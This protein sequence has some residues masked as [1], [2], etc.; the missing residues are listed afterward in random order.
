MICSHPMLRSRAQSHDLPLNELPKIP[1]G[2]SERT[3]LDSRIC[4]KQQ[5]F[6]RRVCSQHEHRLLLCQASASAQGGPLQEQRESEDGTGSRNGTEPHDA[7]LAATEA[8]LEIR[9][10]QQSL[11]GTVSDPEKIQRLVETA[12]LAAVGGVLF[13][14]ATVLK[15]QGYS[16]YVQPMPIVIAAMRWGPAAGRKA[17]TATCFLLLVLLGPL[18]CLTFLLNHGLLAASLGAFWSVQAH[19]ALSVPAAAL[20]RVGGQL[21]YIA[22]TSWTLNENLFA[23]LMSNVYSLLD[24]FNAFIGTSGAPP[25]TV[26]VVVIG[27]M[28]TVNAC[29][30]NFLMHVVYAVLLRSMGY[31][32]TSVPKPVERMIFRQQVA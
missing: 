10:Q 15:L 32:V 19:W 25:P 28:L 8:A 29:L 5:T 21:T 11:P 31:T 16:A 27:S 14:L 30:Y 1:T 3:K 7:S 18:Q 23:L 24:Q 20:V 6:P 22:L 9:K 17:M 4:I 13:T 12:M 2:L 26:V